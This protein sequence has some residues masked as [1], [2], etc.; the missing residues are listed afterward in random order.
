KGAARSH[1]VLRGRAHSR[2]GT[3]GRGSRSGSGGTG[4]DHREKGRR[5][6]CCARS[7]CKGKS[8]E[9]EGA[10]VIQFRILIRSTPFASLTRSFWI[11][12]FATVEEKP[13]RLVAGLGNPGPQYAATRHNIG[14]MVADQLC[15]QFGSTGE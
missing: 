10:E 7:G 8:S 12:D 9:R 4:S 13:I 3:C 14:F 1:C 15:A 5:R 6:R 2:R 11:F